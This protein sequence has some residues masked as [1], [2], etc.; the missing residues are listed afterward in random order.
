MMFCP[1]CG[2]ILAPKDVAKKKKL[3]CLRCNYVAK[4][5]PNVKLQETVEK[6]KKVQVIEEDPMKSY[7]K[8]KE[9]CPKCSN[10][11][12][13]FWT[14]QTRAGDEAETRFFECTKCRHRWREYS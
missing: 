7:P 3:G 14:V 11:E 1:K 2:S 6:A 13:Y 12:A 8:T 5:R 10:R 9:E 4:E